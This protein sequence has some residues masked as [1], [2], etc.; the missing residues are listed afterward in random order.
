MCGHNNNNNNNNNKKN[1]NCSTDTAIKMHSISYIFID[2]TIVDLNTKKMILSWMVS[3]KNQLNNFYD[4]KS[5]F[6]MKVFE[7]LK[8]EHQVRFQV[9]SYMV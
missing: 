1:L 5:Y 7:R 8:N 6:N 2:A 9:I 3:V 4:K